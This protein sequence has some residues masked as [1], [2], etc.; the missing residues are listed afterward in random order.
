MP[1]TFV[2]FVLQSGHYKHGERSEPGVHTDIR[3]RM[4]LLQVQRGAGDAAR[5]VKPLG[6]T[7]EK[8]RDDHW[9]ALVSAK[10]IFNQDR[11]GPDRRLE[12]HEQTAGGVGPQQRGRSHFLFGQT[13][14]QHGVPIGKR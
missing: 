12:C 8:Q 14:L 1:V 9:L 7:G 13:R 3:S 2:E 11:T 4:Q 10:R 6:Q 5:V